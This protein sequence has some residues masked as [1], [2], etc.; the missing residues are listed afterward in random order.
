[1]YGKN[2]IL[3]KLTHH[4]QKHFREFGVSFGRCLRFSHK[5][6]VF[7]LRPCQF[8]CCCTP[9]C[10]HLFCMVLVP[11]N[12]YFVL[13][14]HINFEQ[15]WPEAC[16]FINKE[17]LA[18]VFSCEF[19][20]IFE[21][22]FFTVH[23]WT[24]ASRYRRSTVTMWALIFVHTNNSSKTLAYNIFKIFLSKMISF[25]H[26]DIIYPCLGIMSRCCYCPH[27]SYLF[28]QDKS[29]VSFW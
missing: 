8:F 4:F 22:T 18:Q 11:W 23:P 6:R 24:T 16:N 7:F 15:F 14:N 27:K 25:Y 29:E 5:S 21:N 2:T 20:G 28:Y 17:T 1:M 26:G 10:L 9:R 19:C 12:R 3:G 13:S